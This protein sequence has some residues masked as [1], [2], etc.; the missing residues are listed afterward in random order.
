MG[1]GKTVEVLALVS[2]HRFQGTYQ[3]RRCK[4]SCSVFV[5]NTEFGTGRNYCICH[6]DNYRKPLHPSKSAVAASIIHATRCIQTHRHLS[7]RTQMASNSLRMFF[8]TLCS[9]HIDI[10]VAIYGTGVCRSLGRRRRV[11]VRVRVSPPR[12]PASAAPPRRRAST[13]AGCG[14]SATSATPG[15]TR[16]AAASGARSAVNPRPPFLGL[17]T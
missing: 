5:L 17:D 10:C 6:M 9:I 7:K 13:R 15:C 8:L 2:A 11:R 3:A 4:R 16:P 14:C 1:L 12:W